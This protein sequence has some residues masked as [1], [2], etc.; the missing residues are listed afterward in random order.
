MAP[1][2]TSTSH[3][4]PPQQPRGQRGGGGHRGAHA[5]PEHDGVEEHYGGVTL[6]DA[7]AKIRQLREQQS[8]TAAE[9]AAQVDGLTDALARAEEQHL[10]EMRRVLSSAKQRE[11]FLLDQTDP[12]HAREQAAEEAAARSEAELSSLR[13]ALA[14]SEE[15]RVRLESELEEITAEVA[16]RRAADA[17]GLESRQAEV[18]L[19]KQT[20]ERDAEEIAALRA[21]LDRHRTLLAEEREQWKRTQAEQAEAL[22]GFRRQAA[23]AQL[24]ARWVA[25]AQETLTAR[26]S[27]ARAAQAA[28]ELCGDLLAALRSQ[29]GAAACDAALCSALR[30]PPEHGGCAVSVAR[31][32]SAGIDVAAMLAAMLRGFDP[33][34]AAANVRAGQS[35][36]A[37]CGGAAPSQPPG[38]ITAATAQ[39]AGEAER[40]VRSRSGSAS[41]SPAG[42]P[43]APAA[44]APA[45][46]QPRP[47]AA[48]AE[49]R[50]QTARGLLHRARRLQTEVRDAGRPAEPPP[51]AVEAAATASPRAGSGPR[52]STSSPARSPGISPRTAPAGAPSPPP[53]MAPSVASL[54]LFGG[55]QGNP[56]QQPAPRRGPGSPSPGGARRSRSAPS[57][58]SHRPPQAQRQPTPQGTSISEDPGAG[59]PAAYAQQAWQQ[60]YS[61]PGADWAAWQAQWQAHYGAY[62]SRAQEAYYSAWSPS[63]VSEIPAAVYA[64]L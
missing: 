45:A 26:D 54:A 44:A 8:R 63:A 42:S 17:A 34:R 40:Q 57:G 24:N 38:W 18:A 14:A 1:A 49:E 15:Q 56:Q 7:L 12:T 5:A 6:A 31:A 22:A 25:T 2:R 51:D 19:L 53:I 47:R 16:Q 13:A 3:R 62:A 27:A 20:V 36:A 10:R 4:S 48:T 37:R 30:T 9:H 46:S 28:A 41:P 59:W 35:A 11:A 21:A 58:G 33:V 55:P 39:G 43:R 52:G 23:R 64:T 50:L 32:Q 60:Q 61:Y 29:C